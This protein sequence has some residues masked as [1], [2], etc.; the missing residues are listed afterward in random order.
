MNLENKIVGSRYQIIEKVGNGGMA[1]VYKAKCHVLNRYVAV[2]VLKDEF[3]T[4]EAF[5][6]NKVVEIIQL[7]APS[8]DLNY[9][10]ERWKLNGI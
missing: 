1:T 10:T 5:V 7:V 8:F 4:D 2:K 6:K 9:M 3:T